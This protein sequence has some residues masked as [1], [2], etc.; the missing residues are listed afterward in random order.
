MRRVED[1]PPRR[2]VRNPGVSAGEAGSCLAVLAAALIII[3]LSLRGIAGFYTDYLWFDSLDR[4]DVWGTVLGA[5]V[6]LTL[7]FFGVFFALLWLNLFIADRSA[8]RRFAHPGPGGG[9]AG[10]L[11]RRRRRPV[12]DSC[13]CRCLVRVRPARRRPGCPVAVGGVAAVRQPAGLRHPRPQFDTDIGFYVF[14]LPF[15]TYVVDWAFAAF[16]IIFILTV[17]AHYLNG[18]I[19]MA[20]TT[21]ERT[22]ASVKVHLSAILAVLAVIRAADYW[23]GALRAH[24]FAARGG[25]RCALHRRQRPAAGAVAADRDLVVG[26]RAARHQPAA[27][28]GWTLPDHRGRAVGVRGDRDGQHL[29]RR[30]CSASRSSRTRRAGRS[31]SPSATSTLTRAAYGA[32]C[33]TR[34]SPTSAF[35]YT[36][37]LTADRVRETTATTVRNA[38]VLDPVVVHPTF[39][40]FRSA[41]RLLPDSRER[42][43]TSA[44]TLSH[45]RSTPTAT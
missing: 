30:S 23:L 22:T 39:E 4:T 15:L 12:P 6:V 21:G 7:I 18:G 27:Q 10:P 31:S 9:A 35:A 33:P 37:D 42:W 19:R 16:V 8:H 43:S 20:A 40:R 44:T 24:R 45:R 25:R 34:T 1:M 32:R 2:S 3:A 41:A 38:R 26:G 28:R 13:S 14:Q 17:I 29:S 11:P 36:T 5:K